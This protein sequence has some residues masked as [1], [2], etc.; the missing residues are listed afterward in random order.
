MQKISLSVPSKV[1]LAGE[2]LALKGEPT[3]VMACEP[4]F[5]LTAEKGTGGE[6]QNPFHPQSPAGLL[7]LQ[8]QKIFTDWDMQFSDPYSGAGGFG[9]STAQFVALHELKTMLKQQDH[10]DPADI[11]ELLQ[12]YLEMSVV[13]GGPKP[14][15]ADLVA[16]HLGGVVVFD[17]RHGKVSKSPWLFANLGLCIAKTSNKVATHEHLRTLP[18]FSGE[19]LSLAM[20]QVLDGFSQGHQNMF[21]QG[22]TAYGEALRGLGFVHPQTE[23][24]LNNLDH[25]AILAK[26]GCGAL[27]ADVIAVFYD[28]TGPKAFKEIEAILQ[29]QNCRLVATEKEISRGVSLHKPMNASAFSNQGVSCDY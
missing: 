24:I 2:Y 25:P 3:L 14:S 20:N 16:Q 28:Q 6:N 12:S 10:S 7:W 21:T 26:K 15:G 8:N 5:T 1:F 4:R 19:G 11:R 29:S 9:A 17:R 18:E 22:I 27:G 13:D 23:H